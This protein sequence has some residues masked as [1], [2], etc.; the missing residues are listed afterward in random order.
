MGTPRRTALT[1]TTLA[2]TSALVVAACG[3]GGGE[4]AGAS[5]R[6]SPAVAERAATTPTTAPG[7]DAE[8]PPDSELDLDATLTIS[9]DG[10]P[11]NLDPHREPTQGSTP[12]WTPAYDSLTDIAVT[13]EVRPRLATEWAYSDDGLQ[14]VFTIREGVE[15][16]DGTPLDAQAVKISLDRART[17]EDGTMKNLLATI[18]DVAVTGPSE[19][20][21]TTSEYDASLPSVLG[22]AAGAMLNPTAIEAGFDFTTRSDGTGAYVVTDF[23]PQQTV[24][25]ER[26]DGPPWDPAT[27]KVAGFTLVSVQDYQV[28]LNA[29]QSGQYDLVR[30]NGLGS[31]IDQAV[32]G[33]EF[34]RI[35]VVPNQTLSLWLNINDPALADQRVRQA[36]AFAIDREGLANAVFDGGSECIAASQ[37]YPFEGD[38]LYVEGYDPYHYDP[39]RARALLE[40]ADAVGTRLT[41]TDIGSTSSV[42][43]AQAVQPMLQDVG[44][45]IELQRGTNATAPAFQQGE[46]Q[47]AVIPNAQQPHADITLSRYWLS[48]G[49]YHLAEGA[50]DEIR[51]GM[52]V[53]ADPA[54]SADEVATGY[55]EIAVDLADLAALVPACA[56]AWSMVGRNEV[57][58]IDRRTVLPNMRVVAVLAD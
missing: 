58:G 56:I 41:I 34:T 35:D 38:A 17:L 43:L 10:F 22:T 19:V 14:L 39:D 15:F 2:V 26:A 48:G 11:E 24:T 46:L 31:Q 6:L 53:L 30:L 44:F 55:S 37:M 1:R 49:P 12:F 57:V 9:T 32:G 54:L 8:L 50:D 36:F 28:A 13:G 21:L 4:A 42:N 16:H 27:G 45:E 5:G 51:A 29:L 47:V 3:G 7:D 20:T 23:V 25:Y 52:E 18:T 40:E 33:G